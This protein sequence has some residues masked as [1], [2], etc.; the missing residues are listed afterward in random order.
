MP[1]GRVSIEWRRVPQ[2]D[3]EAVE[4]LWAESGGPNVAPPPRRGFG[5]L[6]LEGNLPRSLDAQ[7]ELAFAEDGVRCRILIPASRLAAL[8]PERSPPA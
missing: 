2:S 5:T 8:E 3:G 1:D 6:V 4:L 7:V